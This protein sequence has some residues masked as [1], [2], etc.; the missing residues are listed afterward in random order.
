MEIRN[1]KQI[2]KGF[3]VGSFDLFVEKWGIVIREMTFFSKDNKSWISFPSRQFVKDNKKCYSP[4]IKFEKNEING[5][6]QDEIL[7]L[8]TIQ[9]PQDDDSNNDLPF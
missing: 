5:K 4:L 6:F 7:K 9:S 2:N 3:V 1:Y 8:L